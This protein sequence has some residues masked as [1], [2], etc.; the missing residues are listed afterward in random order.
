MDVPV[1]GVVLNWFLILLSICIFLIC[2]FFYSTYN[3][4]KNRGIPYE[5]PFL[6]FGNL[7]FVLRKSV[8]D[9][10]YELK[11]K[12]PRDY[13]GIFL[14]W[15]P[16]LMLQ[17]PE[18]ARRIFV[19][20]FEYF[21]DRFLYTGFSD[22]LGSLNLFTVKNPIWSTMRNSLSPMFTASRLKMITELM[23][24]NS[25]ELVGKIRRDH[26]DNNKDVNLKELFSMYTSDTVAYSVFGI[27][28]S[29][30]NDQDSPLWFITNH[31]V[32]WTFWRG[33]EFTMIFFVPAIAALLR[34]QF[35]SDAAT[36]YIKKIFWNV[37]KE[38]KNSGY[39]N[40]KDLVNHLLKLRDNLKLPADSGSDLAD[41][42][43]LAQAAVFILGSIETSSTALSYCLHELA[44]HPEEQEKL[45]NEVLGAL[46]KSG[47][48]T[49]NYDELMELKYM[50]SCINETLRK[51]PPLGYLDR[52]CNQRYKLN[53]DVIIEKGTP[54]FI[55]VLAIHYDEK[56]YPEPN[57]WRPERM[58]NA[59][60]NDNLN[61]T[62]L[63][64]GE[65]PRFCI[66]KRY[67][68]MQIRASLA[69]L[70]AAYKFLPADIP[71]KVETDPYSVILSPKDGLSVKFQAR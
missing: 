21:Q 51:Y 42:L 25:K 48:D 18:F 16:A 28:V 3:Y 40:H 35:F 41:N 49:L 31:M 52:I 15:K 66:G 6:F 27:R 17:T 13:V 38:R 71:Y 70:V 8:W 55:N 58:H 29:V 34:L 63:P 53:D 30:L 26:I 57:Q 10:C 69:Q 4:W 46:K 47:N 9:F 7:S 65:G 20:D 59:S 50:S 23:N 2:C 60:D 45:H 67:G 54:V 61:F 44:H 14:A 68:Y 56:I 19:K 43:M 39:D 24:M 1:L 12:H 33:L 22:P 11:N 64:F 36:D 62:F 37:A 32:K 5:K